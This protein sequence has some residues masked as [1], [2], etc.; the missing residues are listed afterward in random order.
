[1]KAKLNSQTDALRKP[2]LQFIALTRQS[3][4]VNSSRQPKLWLAKLDLTKLNLTRVP[5][6]DEIA[7]G[8]S[9]S[10]LANL[11]LTWRTLQ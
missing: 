9:L 5:S 3:E 10:G 2:D 6:D 11:N 8:I 1:M 7:A 4:E